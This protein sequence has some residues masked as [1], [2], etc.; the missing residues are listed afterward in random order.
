MTTDVSRQARENISHGMMFIV[1]ETDL[2]FAD[3][4]T[5]TLNQDLYEFR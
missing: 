5:R 3:I 4:K 2:R 1:K